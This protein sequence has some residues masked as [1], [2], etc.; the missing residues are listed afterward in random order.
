MNAKSRQYALLL[1][2]LGFFLALVP[3]EAFLVARPARP[4]S[5]QA[6][7]STF[8]TILHSKKNKPA[9]AAAK[10]IQVKMLKSVPGTGQKGDVI[11]VTPAFFN[12]KLRP[13]SSASVISDEEVEKEEAEKKA[14]E[15]ERNA[16]ATALKER[17]EGNPLR[18]QRK[19]GPEGH[20]FGSINPKAVLTAVSEQVDNDQANFLDQKS[21][22]ITALVDSN[23]KKMRGDIKHIGEFQA[24][25]SLTKNISAKLDIVVEAE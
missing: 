7:S 8:A 6:R 11:L 15:K 12:N 17:L 21:V 9:P 25:I 2:G 22:K 23:G 10:K 3:A 1:T 20:L 13:T 5:Q 4:A 16:L 14:V 19:S 24:T 18:F